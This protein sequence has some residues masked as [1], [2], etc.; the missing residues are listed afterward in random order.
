MRASGCSL[1]RFIS[2]LRR[3]VLLC[4]AANVHKRGVAREQFTGNGGAR[5]VR[6]AIRGRPQRRGAEL[7]LARGPQR[8]VRPAGRPARRRAHSP[9][10]A[11]P[12]PAHPLRGLRGGAAKRGLEPC[13]GSHAAAPRSGRGR[14]EERAADVIPV[15][16]PPDHTRLRNLVSKVFTARR[17]AGLRPRIAEL[18]GRL[19]DDALEAGEFDRSRQSPTRCR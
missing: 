19:V 7:L 16:G 4:P 1:A 15:D 2:W 11:G 18:A 12:V 13:A 14:G 9:D 5:R 17:V 3:A 10:A 6:G 8:P